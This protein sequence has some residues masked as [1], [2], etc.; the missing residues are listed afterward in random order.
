MLQDVLALEKLNASRKINYKLNRNI[1]TFLQEI[2]DRNI[3]LWQSTSKDNPEKINSSLPAI[4]QIFVQE[5]K[6]HLQIKTSSPAIKCCPWDDLPYQDLLFELRFAEPFH[7]AFLKDLSLLSECDLLIREITFSLLPK[8]KLI[9][10]LY[11]IGIEE[12]I[13]TEKICQ[14]LKNSGT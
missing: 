5:Y 6:Y 7:R 8:Q 14:A 9:S 2:R 3:G 13:E 11:Y 10:F 1:V 12:M 4:R